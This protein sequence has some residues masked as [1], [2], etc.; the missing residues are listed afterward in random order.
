M[1][2]TCEVS[3]HPLGTSLGEGPIREAHN[4]T[5]YTWYFERFCDVCGRVQ[6]IQRVRKVR[7]LKH[8]RQG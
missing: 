1:K 2:G 5:T 4:E 8:Q 7:Y 3:S 6:G